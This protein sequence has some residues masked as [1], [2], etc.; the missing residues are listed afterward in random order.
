MFASDGGEHVR[1]DQ[2]Q[3]RQ[4]L[5]GL[6]VESD[7]RSKSP[8]LAIVLIGLAPE[9]GRK[10]ARGQI[11]I[12]GSLHEGVR[13]RASQFVDVQFSHCLRIPSSR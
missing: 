13:G 8:D 6:P 2:V 9:P 7:D 10:G 11:Q 3:E 12:V 1:F 5:T 4:A